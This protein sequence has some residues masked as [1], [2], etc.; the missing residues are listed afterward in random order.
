MSIKEPMQNVTNGYKSQYIDLRSIILVCVKAKWFIATV[1]SI[2]A[3]LALVIALNLPN[4]YQSKVLMAPS[5]NSDSAGMA[6]SLSGMASLAGIN[7]SSNEID[8]AALAVEIMRTFTF[9]KGF[10]QQ[11]GVIENLMA[12]KDWNKEMNQVIYDP[13]L[14]N[15]EQKQWLEEDGLSLKP[16]LQK[17]HRQLLKNLYIEQEKSGLYTLTIE[18][19]SPYLAFEWANY[20]VKQ[21]NLEMRK[22]D[23]AQAER[24]INYLSE[25]LETTKLEELR[26]S[27]HG[28]FEKQVRKKM[29]AEVN[30]EYVFKVIEPPIVAER[31]SKPSRALICILAT[32]IGFLLSI[33]IV[34]T[35]SFK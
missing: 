26:A 28:L 16:S 10:M 19:Y 17:S 14:Y 6:G 22:R 7:L 23:I 29:L 21:I 3:I 24:S 5:S 15:S 8:Q 1:T 2:F 11:D 31:K 12:A 25:Q 4:V 33:F 18:H 9:A 30:H 13:A 32:F 27:L 35:R 20:F 34:V